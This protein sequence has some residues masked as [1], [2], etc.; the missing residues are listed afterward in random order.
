MDKETNNKEN[1]AIKD[2]TSWLIYIAKK[3]IE[4]DKLY[5]RAEVILKELDQEFYGDGVDGNFDLNQF[6]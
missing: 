2:N 5:K 1:G 3:F 4:L 6:N